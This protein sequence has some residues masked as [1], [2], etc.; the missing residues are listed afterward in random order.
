MVFSRFYFKFRLLDALLIAT[1]FLRLVTCSMGQFAGLY[2]RWCVSILSF[3][4]LFD[5]KA[6]RIVVR[7]LLTLALLPKNRDALSVTT[8]AVLF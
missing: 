1:G 6:T 8:P 3:V 2:V 5:I 4:I 7:Q